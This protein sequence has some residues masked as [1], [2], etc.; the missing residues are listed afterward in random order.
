MR[1]ITKTGAKSISV[2]K[3][4]SRGYIIS[5]LTSV[6][7]LAVPRSLLFLLTEK[8]RMGEFLSK[9]LISYPSDLTIIKFEQV[10]VAMR[11]PEKV[12]K[13]LKKPLGKVHPDYSAVMKLSEGRRII[14]VGD[15]CTLGL[16]QIGIR[17]H[18]AVFDFRF[19]RKRLQPE[20]VN[21]LKREFKKSR[22]IKNA[23]GTLSDSI[24]KR[25]GALIEEGGAVLIDGEED[26][27]ALAFI[28]SADSDDILV[29][30]QPGKGIVVVEMDKKT[31][32][33]VKELL[34]AA[35]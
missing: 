20:Y 32:K 31:K 22:R 9:A 27:T 2:R 19:M 10:R 4:G 14:S 24:M 12:K 26:L 17:P 13:E 1:P 7:I 29:Y 23:K 5:V 18:L 11:I 15:I 34:S 6:S 30:G 8:I 28:D 3:K 25:A 16:L 35:L 33:K 21:V